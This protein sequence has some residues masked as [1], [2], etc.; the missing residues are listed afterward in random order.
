MKELFNEEQ[1]MVLKEIAKDKDL[2]ERVRWWV[3]QIGE[4]SFCPM[5]KSDQRASK[6]ECNK[7]CFRLWPDLWIYCPCYRHKPAKEAAK[8]ILEETK[9]ETF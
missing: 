2:V 7:L 4:S 3:D 9:N 6:N 8:I 5:T 1:L